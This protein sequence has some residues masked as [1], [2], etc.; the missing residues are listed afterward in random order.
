M[1]A[2]TP[3]AAANAREMRV[4][5][6]DTCWRWVM[7]C[8]PCVVALLRVISSFRTPFSEAGAVPIRKS[9]I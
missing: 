8:A 2:R 9:L 6:F 4:I 5:V 1:A 7:S 3:P